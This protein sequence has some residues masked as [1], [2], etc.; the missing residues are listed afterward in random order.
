MFVP[1]EPLSN[2]S[3]YYKLA[4]IVVNVYVDRLRDPLIVLP[5][6]GY[7]KYNHNATHPS[8][9]ITNTMLPFINCFPYIVKQEKKIN[10]WRMIPSTLP[11]FLNNLP[12]TQTRKPE[13]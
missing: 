8:K 6:F 12:N 7:D 4:V 13:F 11:C 2:S 5:R 9:K 1:M 10:S 3:F